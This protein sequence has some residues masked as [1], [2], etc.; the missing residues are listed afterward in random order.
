LIVAF[1]KHASRYYRKN[2][3]PTAEFDCF[4]SAL[5]YVSRIYGQTPASQFGPLKLKV[6]RQAMIEGRFSRKPLSRKFINKSVNRVRRAFRWGVECEQVRPNVIEGLRSLS[7]LQAG[8]TDAVERDPVSPVDTETLEKT[9][10]HLSHLVADMVDLQLLTGMRPGELCR[11]SPSEIDRSESI[12]QYAPL[13][14]KMSHKQRVRLIAIGPKAQQILSRYLFG[15]SCF[16]G[17]RGEQMTVR[18]YRSAIQLACKKSGIESWSPNQL[19]HNAATQVTKHFGIETARAVLSHSNTKTTA[20]YAEEDFGVAQ[21]V[22]KA[23][24]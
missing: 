20:I 18:A 4:K 3:R 10:V 22:A 2:G 13:D 15:E 9:R 6:C 5:R 21:K 17:K 8:R 1:L 11:L 7:S 23:L 12:W 24:G 14:H 16:L 19:R